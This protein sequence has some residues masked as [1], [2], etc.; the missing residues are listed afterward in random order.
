MQKNILIVDDSQE[1]IFLIKSI[2]SFHNIQLD[3]T[4]SS[5]DAIEI[6]KD[7]EYSLIILDYKMPEMN[8]IE[9][10]AKIREGINQ[11]SNIILITVHVL[12]E[13]ETSKCKELN[14]LNYVKPIM[15]KE[16]LGRIKK[17]LA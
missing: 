4:K 7:K 14:L 17:L 5:T 12:D 6:S 16:F 3:S 11:N 2:F 10:A 1:F 13:E 15:P 9:C 8:G